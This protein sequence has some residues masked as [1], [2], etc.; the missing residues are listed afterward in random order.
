MK[1]DV[2]RRRKN[3][4]KAK[5]TNRNQGVIDQLKLEYYRQRRMYDKKI[6]SDRVESWKRF[7]TEAGK[8][9]WGY[10]YKL[11]CN[12]VR[13]QQAI[14]SIKTENGFTTDWRESAATLL[15]NLFVSDEPLEDSAEQE[16]I[17]WQMT[18][19]YDGEDDSKPVTE[20]E[21]NDI[22]KKMKNGKAAWQ[23]GT[24]WK[25]RLSRGR[26]C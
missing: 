24:E 25:W 26:G 18:Q 10:A 23:V 12:K 11:T 14:N 16:S 1:R 21:L 3:F 2:H 15:H 8:N 7:M 17:T 6:F 22:I 9:P 19:E 20:K 13:G 5:K 4:Q